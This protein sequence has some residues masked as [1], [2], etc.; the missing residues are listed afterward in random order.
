MNE[1]SKATITVEPAGVFRRIAALVY[2][3]FLIG[4]IWFAV[5]GIGVAVNGGEAMPPWANHYFLF[6]ALIIVTFLFYF[7][8]WTHGGQTLGM[9]AW[10][11]KI[12]NLEKN[13]PS[14]VQCLKRFA[15]AILSAGLGFLA[16]FI[17]REKKSFQDMASNTRIVLLPKEKPH[18]HK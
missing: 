16:C 17:N 14:F 8:F 6:P 4:A 12:L 15:V 9:R 10:R 3:A 5:A 18:G 2:D 1:S 11:L 13:P 7:W